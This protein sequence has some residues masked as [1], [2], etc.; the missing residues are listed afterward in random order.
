MIKKHKKLIL[1]IGITLVVAGV[2][3]YGIKKDWF[4]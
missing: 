2:V 4:K 3:Y 1:G